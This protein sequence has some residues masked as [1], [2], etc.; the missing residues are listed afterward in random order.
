[1]KGELEELG[2]EYENVQSISKIQTQIL[3]LTK[4]QVNIFKDDGTFKSTYDILEQISKV[5]DDLSDTSKASL[6]EILFGKLR[7]NQGV[8][9]ISA[10]KSGQVQKAYQTA[11]DS[12]GSAMKE[13]ERYMD[14]IQAKTM[15][16][17]ASWQNLSQHM[18]SSEFLK[19]GVDVLRSFVDL[20][21]LLIQNLG[22]LGTILPGIAGFKVFNY[23]SKNGESGIGSI[24]DQ[25]K[26]LF[27]DNGADRLNS[28]VESFNS[29]TQSAD[30]FAK[31][32]EKVYPGMG[33]YFSTLGE[34][35]ASV[36]GLTQAYVANGHAVEELSNKTRALAMVKNVLTS[37]GV[38][39]IVGIAS[40]GIKEL[41]KQVSD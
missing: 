4:G 15:Q 34:G 14:S 31:T 26:G 40:W 22:T 38:G 19:G 30:E 28:I 21:D 7:A 17:D 32:I 37:V 41:S 3:N 23:L 33:S 1:M 12:S 8:A 25:I 39:A 10:F 29:G 9:L 2:E 36:E 18:L 5:Y 11:L 16:L 13:Q 27:A 20:T 35:Q 6:T 24:A